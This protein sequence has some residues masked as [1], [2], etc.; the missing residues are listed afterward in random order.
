VCGSFLAQRSQH[1]CCH[2]NREALL[3]SMH[4]PLKG[5]H[6]ASLLPRGHGSDPG[7]A[8]ECRGAGASLPLVQLPRAVT[9][10][11]WLLA[12]GIGQQGTLVGPTELSWLG[13]LLP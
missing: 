3:H 5:P 9:P 6:L 7:G 13:L 11:C 2:C 12:E 1:C 4:T 10:G 8:G